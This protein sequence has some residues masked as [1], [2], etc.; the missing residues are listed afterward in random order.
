M[1][2]LNSVQMGEAD[3]YTIEYIGIPSAV[4]MENAA[5]GIFQVIEKLDLGKGRIGIF[6]GAGNNGGDG[7]ALA[8][9]CFNAGFK[10]ELFLS[11]DPEKLKGDPFVNFKILEHYPIPVL[12]AFEDVIENRYDLI[13]DSLFGTGLSRPLEGK[14]R[15]LIDKINN[16][17]GIKL[18]VDIPSG[19]SGNTN[20]LIGDCFK[21]DITVT[22][23]RP[24]IPHKVYP[25]K[26]FCG[27]VEVADI[28]IPDFAVENVKP[29]IYEIT[30]KNITKLSKRKPDS[31]KGKFGHAVIIGGS[32]GKTGAP[33]I[34]SRS[35][36]RTGAGLTT[37]I[38]PYLL[39]IPA[40][41]SDAEIMSYY[42]GS[43]FCFG[44]KDTDKILGFIENKT[45]VGLGPG[46]GRDKDTITFTKNII[47][48]SQLPLV[49]DA[50]GLYGLDEQ[51]FNNLK[52]RAVITPHVGEFARIVNESKENVINKKLELTTDFA[53]K[54]GIVTV[55]KSAD[56]VIANPDGKIFVLNRGTPA[57]AKGGSGD[58]LT[59]IITS[60]ISQGHSLDDAA[61]LGTW[62]MGKTAEHLT[63]K[64]NERFLIS[65][66]IINNLWIV[67]NELYRNK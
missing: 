9:K 64:Y 25:A 45:V 54:Y 59:G 53:V 38:L 2:I 11:T 67:L 65:G 44:E 15:K 17:D 43:G 37:I 28:S 8:R 27:K 12:N 3:K 62:I 22:M 29:F 1:E 18:A 39:N 47:Q 55:L 5:S 40:E 60:F 57:L 56:T 41:M 48:Q 10:V 20:A 61:I 50:D 7:I 35:C 23:C 24:K 32:P 19:L 49:I 34:A 42:A 51:D 36:I 63:E 52:Y 14:Y 46:I 21:A 6:A 4:L 31:H 58:C 26:K 66:D 13:V 33:I 16:L 30:D